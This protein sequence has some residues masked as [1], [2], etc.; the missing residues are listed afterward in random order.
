MLTG[1]A[2]LL[3]VSHAIGE[4][5]AWPP[6]PMALACW[7]YVAV[8]GSLIGYTAYLI[9]LERTTPALATSYT[10]QSGRRPDSGRTLGQEWSQVRLAVMIV[11]SGVVLLMS[12]R[13]DGG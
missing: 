4:S 10:C 3:I 8:A 12:R 9:L 11:L 2:L 13:A 7:L 6:T 1:G 5:P